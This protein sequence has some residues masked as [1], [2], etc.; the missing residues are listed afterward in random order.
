MAD[1]T[2]YPYVHYL[3][4][5]SIDAVIKNKR[6]IAEGHPN[7]PHEVYAWYKTPDPL[8]MEMVECINS[9][10]DLAEKTQKKFE[11]VAHNFE[12]FAKKIVEN[13]EKI[14]ENYGKF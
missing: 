11:I 12:I 2:P 3:H 13:S 8:I 4:N 6:L 7:A 5:N 1:Y 14:E 9:L 10:I